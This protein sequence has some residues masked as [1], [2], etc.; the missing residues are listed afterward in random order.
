MKPNASRRVPVE[1]AGIH[2]CLL[3]LRAEVAASS[4]TVEEVADDGVLVLQVVVQAE[5]L[6]GEVLADD[7]HLEVG[8]VAPAELHREAP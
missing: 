1:D 4:A 6:R 7:R 2:S 3:L 8:A 5:A